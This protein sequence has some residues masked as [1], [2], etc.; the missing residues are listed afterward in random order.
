M[1]PARPLLLALAVALLV[2]GCSSADEDE[3][4]ATATTPAAP[5]GASARSCAGTIAGTSDLRVTGVGCEVGHA[6]VTAWADKSGCTPAGAASRASCSIYDGY[7]C[8]G[9]ATDRG[10]AVSCAR[11]GSSVAFLARSRLR[12]TNGD[13]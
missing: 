1:S 13:T 7:L 2:A 10:F 4:T 6:V 11:P 12:V 5:A 3:P 8:L 9:A